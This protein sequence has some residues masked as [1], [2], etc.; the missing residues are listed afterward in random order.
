MV[1]TEAVPVT[2]STPAA[3]AAATMA[4]T[5]SASSGTTLNVADDPK[6][7]KILVDGK[8]MTL[9]M[10]K[11]DEPNKSNCSGNCLKAWPPLMVQGDVKAGD[12]VDQSLIGAATLADGS[13]IVTYNK[14]PLYYYAADSKPGD[15]TGQGVNNVWYVV[16]ADG[17]P[18]GE[19]STG[20]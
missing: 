2:G 8:G 12:G 16:A 5:T 18:V 1:T 3:T 14:M 19:S 17:T 6:L 11:K 4:A 15:T 13:K 10:F 20:Y 7:G 9:Y